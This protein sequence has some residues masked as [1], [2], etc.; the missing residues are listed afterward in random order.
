VVGVGDELTILLLL[1]LLLV[2]VDANGDDDV[3]GRLVGIGGGG[4]DGG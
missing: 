2:T 4:V 3:L 1:L